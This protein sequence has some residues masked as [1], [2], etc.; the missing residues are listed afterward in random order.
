MTRNAEVERYLGEAVSWEADRV[1][2]AESATR[3]AWWAATGLA[4]LLGLSLVANLSLS[5]MTKVFPFL[6]R[7]DNATGIV[8][9]V[10]MYTGSVDQ[11]ELVARVLLNQY[12]IACERYFYATAEADYEACGAFNSPQRNQAMLAAWDRANPQSP[13]NLYKDGTAVRVQVSAIS[14]LKPAS[15]INDLAQIRFIRFI[16]PGGVGE[17]KATH[18]IATLQYAWAKPPTDDRQRTINPL[19]FRVVDYRKEAEIVVEPATPAA[20]TGPGQ[21]Q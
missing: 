7:V 15:G 3:K 8:D 21:G 9:V 20:L 14:F 6:I 4:T 16:R 12:V 2:K 17:E 19:G 11:G 10:P 18:W 5:L 13:L 1:H